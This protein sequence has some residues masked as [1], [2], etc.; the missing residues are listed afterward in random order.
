MSPLAYIL[1]HKIVAIL[2]GV[3]PTE[4]LSVANALH[5]GGIRILEVTLNSHDAL[6]QIE[7]LVYNAD[8]EMLI[9]AGTVLNA[10][11]AKNA[12]Q[13]GAAF[14]ISPVVDAAVIALAKDHNLVSIPG[15]YTA[16]E[17]VQAH[18]SGGDIIKVFPVTD[19]A[20]FKALQAPLNHICMMPTGGVTL[21]TICAFKQTGAAAFGIGSAL[22][23]A[24]RVDEQ[25][26][27]NLTENARR[28]IKAVQ[29]E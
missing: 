17:I 22:V 3:T 12:I 24:A 13:A 8:R 21:D 16:T 27:M 5:A 2:R 18:R 25:Y 9:G 6:S 26:L 7:Q 23:H 10:A 20:Y 4:V 29:E 15:A 28:F 1:Q 19:V 11:D 14:L